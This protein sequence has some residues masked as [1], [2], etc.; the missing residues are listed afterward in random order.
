MADEV[1]S[2]SGLLTAVGSY[3]YARADRE[4]SRLATA[5]SNPRDLVHQVAFPLMR[6]TGER[7][8]NGK[9]TIAQEHMITSLLSGLFASLLRLYAPANPPARVLMATPENEHHG[10]GILAAAMLTAA[11]G[12]GAIH[13]GTNLPTRE[14]IQAAQKTEANAVLLG[15]RGA[16]HE[17]AIPVLQEIQNKLF[18]RTQLW[19]GG[20]NAQI[21]RA[22]EQMGWTLLKDFDVLERQLGFLGAR[23]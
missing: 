10:F 16:E 6:I 13:L 2:L 11:G 23:F 5:T 8:H 7:C 1:T 14:I 4:L 17:T 22:A 3:D 21:S 12:L 20:A 9:F 18:R 15:F 19:V